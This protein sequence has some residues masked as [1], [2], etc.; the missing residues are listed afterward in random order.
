MEPRLIQSQQ[1]KMVLSPQI[2]QYLKILQ[3]PLFELTQAIDLELSQNPLLE[4]KR[5]ESDSNSDAE[6]NTDQ[7]SQTT[8]EM[9]LGEDYNKLEQMEANFGENYSY[10]DNSPTPSRKQELQELKDYQESSLTEE[11]TLFDHLMKQIRLLDF[12]EAEIAICNE[13]I[14][15]L[16]EHGYLTVTPQEI[17][18]TQGVEITL[19]E[20]VL[21]RI[22][23]LDPPGI[24][25]RNLQETLLLQLE[26]IPE[27]E[28]ARRIVKEEIELLEKR[29]V[30]QIAKNM[31]MDISL[32][33]KEIERITR[34]EPR[35]GRKFYKADSITV[36]PDVIISYADDAET[37]LKV[38]IVNERIP[39]LRINPYYRNM[40][41][42]TD[43]DDK[44]KLF[45]KEK[46]Q[47]AMDFMRAMS[48][49][50]S[51]IHEIA[52]TIVKEQPEF[53]AKGFSHLK[54][55][56]LKDIA[57][58]LGIHESTVSRAISGKYVQ[59]PRGT[60]AL[61]SFFSNKVETSSGEAESQKS[62]MAKIKD[63]VEKENPAKPLS[64][65]TIVKELNKDGMIIARRTV[66]KY[67]E[68]LKILPSYM[69]KQK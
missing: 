29:N 32:I 50:Q 37:K 68:M 44:T 21:A 49:R 42:K 24:A 66:A 67:R 41:R 20:K 25:A 27:T 30:T 65:Q 16:N 61:R 38:E 53:F 43:L 28:L 5:S 9:N 51:T 2:R 14:G 12:N 6:N 13:I 63:M 47:N 62:I 23:Q 26:R 36:T 54:P 46:L 31:G 64:D 48:Q 17:A 39:K 8:P 33:R 22:Q 57:D 59:T 19:V 3:M 45:I 60:F 69:R 11:E 56:R 1:Q 52:K 10:D 55:M 7:E 58:T 34:L 18:E 4:E 35:P 15:N 40:L